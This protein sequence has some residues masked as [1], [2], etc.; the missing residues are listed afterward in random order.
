MEDE[1]LNQS[2]RRV[3]TERPGGMATASGPAAA[4]SGSYLPWIAVGAVVVGAAGAVVGLL[5]QPHRART[6]PWKAGYP[7]DLTPPHGDKLLPHE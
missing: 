6:G 7:G 2:F 3:D 4:G 5:Q 1:M